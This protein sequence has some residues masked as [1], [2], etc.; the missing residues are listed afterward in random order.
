MKELYHA[1]RKATV[2]RKLRLYLLGS[3]AAALTGLFVA[4]ITAIHYDFSVP[5][6]VAM[7]VLAAALATGIYA[8]LQGRIL[9]LYRADKLMNQM[10]QGEHETVEGVFR[11]FAEGK[12]MNSGVMMYK[13]LLDEGKRVGKEPVFRALSIPA[14]FGKPQIREGTVFR[15]ETVESIVVASQLPTSPDVDPTAGKYQMS[16][17]VILV[18]ILVTALLWCGLYGAVHKQPADRILN[19]AVCT[20]AHHEETEDAVAQAMQMDGVDVEF[21]YTN[22]IE[23]ET[24][25][26]YLATFGA[27]EAD[28]LVLNGDQFLG[29]Y[30]NDTHPLKTEEIAAALGFEPQYAA[31]A[32][33]ERT[34]VVLYIPDD[35][36]YNAN[37]PGLFDWIAVE[38]DV[39]LVAAIRYGSDHADSGNADLAFVHL[40]GYLADK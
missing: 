13:L 14:I 22:T 33:G 6:T 2:N 17:P 19:V 1:E 39:A 32:A 38:K 18:I 28:I 21:S 5:V 27:M 7:G 12:S 11:G 29:V 36:A 40:L 16:I 8:V 9:P 15:A 25:A 31:N 10:Q 37:F 24:V 34:G 35:P 4:V 23:P 20:P 26:M 30:E 3:A